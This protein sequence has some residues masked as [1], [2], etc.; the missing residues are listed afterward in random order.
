METIIIDLDRYKSKT[1]R[2]YSGR[3]RG[4]AVRKELNL[5]FVDNSPDV[6]FIKVPLDTISINSSFFLGMFG[7]SV[8]KL[9]EQ[10]FRKKYVFQAKEV[11][12][13]NIDE[14]IVRALKEKSVI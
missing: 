5:D 10:G 14:G 9:T 4:E 3:D 13:R 12:N 2:V 8:R 7:E 11:I 6:I 1:S